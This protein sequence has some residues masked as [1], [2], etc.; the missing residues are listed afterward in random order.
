M[1]CCSCLTGG[2]GTD[3]VSDC[4]GCSAD[5]QNCVKYGGGGGCVA[6]GRCSCGSPGPS[7]P[8]PPGPSAQIRGT[9][10]PT[11]FVSSEQAAIDLVQSLAATGVTRIYVDVWN[12]GKAYFDSPAI[13]AFAG[14]AAIGPDHLAWFAQAARANAQPLEVYAWFEYGF[15]AC[16][17]DSPA[18]NAFAEAADAAGW[19]IGQHG[20]WQWMDPAKA[21]PLLEQMLTEATS[22]AYA[23]IVAQL[24]DHFACPAELGTCSAAAMDTAAVRL[25]KIARSLAPAPID[26][27]KGT[28]NVGWVSWAEQGLFAEYVPQLYSSSSASF[29]QALAYTKSMIP[30]SAF[31]NL[32]AGVRVDGSGSPTAWEEVDKMLDE[33]SSQGVGASVWYADGITNLYPDEFAAKWSKASGDEGRSMVILA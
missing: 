17:G 10:I 24:D 3:C 5:C 19:L 31:A 18:G 21:T 20:G 30:S 32:V 27:A 11:S 33:A 26:F 9:W 7:P 16:Y 1:S 2:G 13:R 22:S 6:Q 25:S 4:G 28:L 15:M 8:S 23:G 14:D 12:N 29:S